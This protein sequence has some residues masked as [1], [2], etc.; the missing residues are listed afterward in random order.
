[1]KTY[2]GYVSM[3]ATSSTYR[4]HISQKNRTVYILHGFKPKISH[5]AKILPVLLNEPLV[6]VTMRSCTITLFQKTEE[7]DL[8]TQ[9]LAGPQERH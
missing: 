6:L 1:M 7:A 3:L 5:F 9:A 2:I 8:Q 4:A